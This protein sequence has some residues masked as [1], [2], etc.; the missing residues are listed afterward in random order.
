MA[1]QVGEVQRIRREAE[2][3]DSNS[4]EYGPKL[5]EIFELMRK[6]Q[7]EISSKYRLLWLCVKFIFC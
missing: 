3:V 2:D 7:G 5:L 1:S 4:A 6:E